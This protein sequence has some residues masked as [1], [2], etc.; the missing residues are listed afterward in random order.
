MRYILAGNAPGYSVHFRGHTWVSDNHLF[1]K[2]G[3]Y[4]NPRD[5]TRL[6]K[7]LTQAPTPALE[8]V[9]E[10]LLQDVLHHNLWE[11]RPDEGAAV[12]LRQTVDSGVKPHKQALTR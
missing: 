2:R 1:H 5:R 11:V 6:G 7:G 8:H 12:E 4:F 10:K 3:N 9:F